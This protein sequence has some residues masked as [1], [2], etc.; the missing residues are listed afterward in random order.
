MNQN[1]YCALEKKIDAS[2]GRLADHLHTLPPSSL[3]ADQS[4]RHRPD[5]RILNRLEELREALFLFCGVEDLELSERPSNCLRSQ[6]ICTISQLVKRSPADL[7][8]IRN[9]GANSL[10][11]IKQVLSLRNL[12]L[13]MDLRFGGQPEFAEDDE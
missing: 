4:M 6:H 11:E 3:A 2:I 9:F 8:K 12:S 5:Q 10:K 7:L 1:E 13:G